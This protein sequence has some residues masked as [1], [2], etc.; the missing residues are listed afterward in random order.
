MKAVDLRVK[1][2]DNLTRVVR[3]GGSSGRISVPKSWIGRR[4][5]IILLDDPAEQKE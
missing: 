2:F 4:A 5:Q 1:G 3:D